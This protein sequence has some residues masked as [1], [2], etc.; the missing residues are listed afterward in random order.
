MLTLKYY[1]VL[2]TNQHFP[3]K[4]SHSVAAFFVEKLSL[5]NLTLGNQACMCHTVHETTIFQ[6][7]KFSNQLFRFWF[8]EVLILVVVEKFS[9]I[10]KCFFPYHVNSFISGCTPHCRW[11]HGFLFSLA[12]ILLEFTWGVVLQR[13]CK[14]IC[15]VL[16]LCIVIVYQC[17]FEIFVTWFHTVKQRPTLCLV[18]LAKV[19]ICDNAMF[20]CH[21]QL[22][23]RDVMCG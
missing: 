3:W 11:K 19:R 4:T 15:F 20:L 13:T 9:S 6:S 14:C 22:P 2:R 23:P 18:F 17:I 1:L 16:F 8:I 21:N 7:F 10:S 12:D 5:K